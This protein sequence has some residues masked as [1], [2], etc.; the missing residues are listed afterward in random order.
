MAR[1]GTDIS[2]MLLDIIKAVAI[3]IS[4]FIVIRALLQAI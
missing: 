3:A 2:D 4:G 1:R